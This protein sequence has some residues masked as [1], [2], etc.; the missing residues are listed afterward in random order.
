VVTKEEREQRRRIMRACKKWS[1]QMWLTSWKKEVQYAESL[2]EVGENYRRCAACEA[3][4]RYKHLTLTF[5]LDA[6]ADMT[7]EELERTVIHELLHAIVEELRSAP[8]NV[9]LAHEERVVTH[10]TDVIWGMA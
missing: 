3:D 8:K 2:G 9:R 4:W 1:E 10:L 7:D 6:V 5:A